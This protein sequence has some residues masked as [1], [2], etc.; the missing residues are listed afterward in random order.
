MQKLTK[1]AAALL[2]TANL[3]LEQELGKAD[4]YRN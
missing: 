4:P 1:A 2:H 3:Y